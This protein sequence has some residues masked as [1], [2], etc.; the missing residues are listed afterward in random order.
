M[1]VVLE[2]QKLLTWFPRDENQDYTPADIPIAGRVMSV[3][4]RP[5]QEMRSS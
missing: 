1:P 4:R 5:V 3:S 2:P